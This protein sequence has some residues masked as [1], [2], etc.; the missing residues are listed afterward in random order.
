MIALAAQKNSEDESV[1]LGGDSLDIGWHIVF[2]L[3]FHNEST[4]RIQEFIEKRKLTIEL[5]FTLQFEPVC[6]SFFFGKV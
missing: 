4:R 6:S 5:P 1:G 3:R 2:E